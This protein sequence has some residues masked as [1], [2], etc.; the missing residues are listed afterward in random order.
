MKVKEQEVQ[1]R[2]EEEVQDDLLDDQLLGQEVGAIAQR[3][4]LK[5]LEKLSEHFTKIN[6][7]SC[8]YLVIYSSGCIF[9]LM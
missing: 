8:I 6:F 1:H 3:N 2:L 4:N 9:N 5:N 7:G